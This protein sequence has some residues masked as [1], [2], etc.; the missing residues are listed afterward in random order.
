MNSPS[1]PLIM[2]AGRSF[3][4]NVVITICMITTKTNDYYWRNS[5]VS[6]KPKQCVNASCSN[7]FYVPDYKL[8][9]CLQCQTCVDKRNE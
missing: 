1:Q 2:V 4:R 7:V 3:T 9:M 8:H 6:L 5:I